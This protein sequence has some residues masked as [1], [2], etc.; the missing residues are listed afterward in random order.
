[1]PFLFSVHSWTNN[2]ILG[3]VWDY[4]CIEATDLAF[5]SDFWSCSY[6]ASHFWGIQWPTVVTV[7]A[8]APFWELGTNSWLSLLLTYFSCQIVHFV[9]FNHSI[10]FHLLQ[11]TIWQPTVIL[12]LTV[13][14][15]FFLFQLVTTLGWSIAK[16]PPFWCTSKNLHFHHGLSAES[17]SAN[18][19]FTLLASSPF[20]DPTEP[21]R[22]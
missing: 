10:A 15:A 2:S 1:M 19:M 12:L 7:F 4:Y 6:C 3:I 17:W 22:R 9:T 20:S 21:A 13:F 18:C 11:C 14:F 5:L 8:F 16:G